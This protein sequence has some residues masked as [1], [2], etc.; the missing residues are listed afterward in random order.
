MTALSNARNTTEILCHTQK[1]YRTRTVKDNTKIY[2][3]SMIAINGSTNKA[4]PAA[5]AAGLI[6]IGRAEGF[7]AD[8]RVIAKSG[9]FKFDNASAT[10]EKL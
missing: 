7:T 1:L 10:A 5:D 2:T 4:E 9:V 6:V 8:G 3:G